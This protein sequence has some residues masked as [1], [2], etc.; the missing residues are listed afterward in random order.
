MAKQTKQMSI[1]LV[2]DVKD[3]GEL[4]TETYKAPN[5]IPFSKLIKATTALE[6]LEEKTEMESMEI[7]F[8]VVCDLY[9]NQFTVQELM[10]GL[11]SR[12]AVSI[13]QENIQQLSGQNEAE[14]QAN[15][16]AVTK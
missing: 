8:Q 10:D 9:N 1:E 6:G 2:T 13:I 14:Q 16:K 4:V 15:L 12:N 5:F 3:N 7:T 11:D